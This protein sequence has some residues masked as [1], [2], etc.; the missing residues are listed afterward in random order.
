MGIADGERRSIHVDEPTWRKAKI[1]AAAFG[2]PIYAVVTQA[3]NEMAEKYLMTLEAL[4]KE[5]DSE[6][7]HSEGTSHRGDEGS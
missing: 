5:V 2:V 3:I 7:L 4:M 1:L 6:S